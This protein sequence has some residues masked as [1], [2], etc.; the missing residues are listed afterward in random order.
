MGIVSERPCIM[1]QRLPVR[2]LL[3]IFSCSFTLAACS[4][5]LALHP[6][7]KSAVCSLRQARILPLPFSIL[8]QNFLMSASHAV[9]RLP[10]PAVGVEVASSAANATVAPRQKHSDTSENSDVHETHMLKSEDAREARR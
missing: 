1:L 5:M 2:C 8:A 9:Q 6:S 7:D 4:A 3:T 10:V